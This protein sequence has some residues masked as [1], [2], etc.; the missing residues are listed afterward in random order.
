MIKQQGL[1]LFSAGDISKEALSEEN[2]FLYNE[3]LVARKASEITSQHVVEQFVKMNELLEDLEEKIALETELKEQL[4]DKL[5]EADIREQELAAARKAAEAANRIKSDFLANMSHEIRTPMNAII[6]M[7]ELAL[8]ASKDPKQREYLKVIRSSARSLLG[9]IND[10]LDF[11]KIE[12][13]KLKLDA[14]PFKL[15]DLLDEVTDIFRE[16]IS[17]KELELILDVAL[18]STIWLV[19][20]SMRLRQV[21]INLINNAFKFTDQ[22]E[23]ILRV[24]VAERNDQKV[25]LAFK[26]T[27]TGIG[28]PSDKLGDLF[29]AFTQVDSTTSRKYSGTGLGLAISQELVTMMGGEA[30]KVESELGKGSTF[31]FELPFE[32]KEIK[33]KTKKIIP[34]EILT[35]KILIVEDNRASQLMIQRMLESFSIKSSVVETAEKALNILKGDHGFGLVLM[36]WRLPGIDGLTAAEEILKIDV[37]KKIPIVLMSAFGREK[38]I[39][40]AN[41]LG[42]KGYLTKP[43]KQS[44]LFD[45]IMDSLGYFTKSEVREVAPFAKNDSNNALILVVEDNKANQFVISELL[46]VAGY[47]VD[48][49]ENGKRGLE[50]LKLKKYGAILMDVQMPEMDG[51]EAT[52]RIR[53]EMGDTSPPIIAMTANALKGDREKCLESGMNDYISKPIDRIELYSILKKWLPSD[54]GFL[55]DQEIPEETDPSITTPGYPTL[56]G[57]DV[58]GVLQRLII[59]WEECKKFLLNFYDVQESMQQ[60]LKLAVES[61]DRNSIKLYAHTFVGASSNIGAYLVQDAAKKLERIAHQAGEDEILAAFSYL[62]RELSLVNKSIEAVAVEEKPETDR[63]KKTKAVDLDLYLDICRKLIRPLEESD[64]SEISS[65][66][67]SLMEMTAP[68]K[69]EDNVDQLYE[70]INNYQYEEAGRILVVIIEKIEEH[71]LRAVGQL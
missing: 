42:L 32:I 3:V 11:S 47:A 6:G 12:A 31:S 64:L 14:I 56:P 59:S 68:E 19:G 43:I 21:V 4:S 55:K 69:L 23:I 7:S 51:Y 58:P 37:D 63:Q 60:N 5:H 65:I 66:T 40:R 26:F 25:R 41:D 45:V 71:L 36:D 10:I 1:N 34:K 17:K 61:L 20:D 50:A 2:A 46:S 15:R 54:D 33:E 62:T 8:D 35:L 30:I 39:R 9:I 28:I 44:D 29:E 70:F 24:S 16:S 53:E 27:D 57:I 18:D 22:G 52:R 38:E 49:A 67:D 13:G 48:I